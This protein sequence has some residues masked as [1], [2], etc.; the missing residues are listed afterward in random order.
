MRRVK[1]GA[2]IT[3]KLALYSAP[4]SSGCILWNGARCGQGY[5]RV[6]WKGRVRQA[7]HLAYES[8][9]GEIPAG[10]VIC[11][12]CDTPAC[13][14]PDHLFVG[15][16]ADNVA[17]KV[18]KGR[19]DRGEEAGP[20]KLSEAQARAILADGRSQYRIARDYGVTQSAVSYLKR[21]LTW[22]HLHG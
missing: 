22:R 4:H 7:S 8:K 13:I 15:T 19:Q 3:E 5:G 11:H 2:S 10:M 20:A 9:V 12:R 17:D 1:Q 21:G 18:A 16:H 6:Y 14:N